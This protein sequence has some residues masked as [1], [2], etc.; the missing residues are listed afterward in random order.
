MQL[1][2]LGIWEVHA[3]AAG[4]QGIANWQSSCTQ[5]CNC[6]CNGTI[7]PRSAGV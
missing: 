3:L 2:Q 4:N 6:N 5:S 1:V 7:G